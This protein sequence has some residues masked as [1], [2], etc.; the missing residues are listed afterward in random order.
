MTEKQRGIIARNLLNGKLERF[1]AHAVVLATG[2]YG[3][4]STSLPMR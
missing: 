2:G 3:N 4:G 1:S